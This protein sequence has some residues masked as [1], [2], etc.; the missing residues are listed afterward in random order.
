MTNSKFRNRI[1]IITVFAVITTILAVPLIAVHAEAGVK[2]EL[3]SDTSEVI[4]GDIITVELALDS[5][6]NLTRFGS[7]EIMFD[8]SGVSFAGLDRGPDIPSTFYIGHTDSTGVIVVSGLDTTVESQ[9]LAN[10]TAPTADPEGN[11]VDPPEDPSMRRDE[12]TVLCKINFEVSEAAKS[13]LRFWIGNA[14][15]FRNSSMKEVSVTI[16]SPLSVSV[17]TVVSTDSSLAM[18]SIDGATLTPS[19]SPG[20]FEYR[21]SVPRSVTDLVVSA[22]PSNR[23]GQIYVSGQNGLI[24]GENQLTVSVLAQDQK[25][26]S[27]YTVT[28][29]REQSFVPPGATVTDSFGVTYKFADFSENLSLPDG[30]YQSEIFLEERYVPAFRMEGMKDVILYLTS[31]SGETDFYVYSPLS[32]MILKFDSKN[33]FFR[34]SQLLTVIPVPDGVSPPEG[35]RPETVLFRG[36]DVEG[37]VSP[38]GKVKVLYMQDDSGKALF[39]TADAK[40]NDLYPYIPHT[41]TETPSFLVPFIVLLIF[42]VAEAAMLVIIVYQLRKRKPHTPK[43]RRV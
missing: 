6:P 17:N 1:A 38:D 9:I 18:L 41:R 30:F 14:A 27:I 35:F 21:A 31:P 43:V 26:N 22:I 13:E 39:Y 20:L 42:S 10:Q 12:R 11:P 4:P 28:V 3:R 33:V 19:F 23:A 34:L 8:A 37:Y 40:N 2:V 7:V 29:T 15:G 32:N 24:V 16:G 5:F 25:T 36:Q